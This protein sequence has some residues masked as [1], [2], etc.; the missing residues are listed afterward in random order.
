MRSYGLFY[1]AG[2]C[3]LGQIATAVFVEAPANHAVFAALALLFFVFIQGLTTTLGRLWVHDGSLRSAHL[4]PQTRRRY[5]E[6]DAA[7]SAFHSLCRGLADGRMEAENQAARIRVNWIENQGWNLSGLVNSPLS[8]SQ[9][10]TSSLGAT[11]AYWNPSGL[12]K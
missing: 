4:D 2:L 12:A 3:T 5:D 9:G 6:H 1:I 7:N 11:G 10:Q 8:S